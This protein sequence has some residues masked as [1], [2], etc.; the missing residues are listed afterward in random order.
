[1]GVV[2]VWGGVGCGVWGG[3]PRE[4]RRKGGGTRNDGDEEKKNGGKRKEKMGHK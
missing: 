3:V 2:R 1:M 4:Q